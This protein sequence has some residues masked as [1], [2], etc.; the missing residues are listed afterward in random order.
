MDLSGAQDRPPALSGRGVMLLISAH[1]ALA[2]AETACILAEVSAYRTVPGQV[3][4]RSLL[5]AACKILL[6]LPVWWVVIRR[7][8]GRAWPLRLA[9]HSIAL[10]AFLFGWSALYHGAVDRIGLLPIHPASIPWNYYNGT[11]V[12]A[13]QFAILH[14]VRE[15]QLARRRMELATELQHSAAK[16]ELRALRAQVMPHF[17][18][19]TLHALS[20]AAPPESE[21]LRRRIALLGSLLRYALESSERDVVTLQEELQFAR[22]YLDLEKARLGD[23][24]TVSYDIDPAALGAL[25]PPV[26]L[27]PLVENALKHGIACHRQGGVLTLSIARR[28]GCAVVRVRDSAEGTR[29]PTP[30]GSGVG[31]RNIEARL[32]GL[33]DRARLSARPLP[34]GF[35][36][37]ISVPA[38]GS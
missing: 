14:L 18:F 29:A 31:L 25:V 30:S 9:V 13:A 37:E 12:Y 2:V 5:D 19:N 16:A 11:V 1:A 23:R 6:T 32:R 33:G 20:A 15:Q 7:L 36:A 24:L 3:L 21:E 4:A 35:E 22:D 28:N 27:Q 8:D 38:P 10:P 17:L 26:V 34:T